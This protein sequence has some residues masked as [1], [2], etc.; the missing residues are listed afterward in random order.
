MHNFQEVLKLA[1]GLVESEESRI[2]LRLLPRPQVELDDLV[3][4]MEILVRVPVGERPIL[5]LA[6]DLDG[7]GFTDLVSGNTDTLVWLGGPTRELLP[8][9][10]SPPSPALI[11]DMSPWPISTATIFPIYFGPV[12]AG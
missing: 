9:H 7:D 5:L 8:P 3:V 2:D 4:P 12:L 11:P 6:A 10:P 1:S